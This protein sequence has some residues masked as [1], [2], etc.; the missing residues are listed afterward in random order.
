MTET[1][2]LPET[3]LPEPAALPEPEPQ[4]RCTLPILLELVKHFLPD[5][6]DDAAIL[7]LQL[8]AASPAHRVP[9][10]TGNALTVKG[11]A[12]LGEHRGLLL[13][14]VD[15]ICHRWRARPERPEESFPKGFPD[16]SPPNLPQ[17][18]TS[19]S[20]AL[21][22]LRGELANIIGD[23]VGDALGDAVGGAITAAIGGADK[24]VEAAAENE[25]T[26]E[27][28][29]PKEGTADQKKPAPKAK[30]KKT[31]EKKTEVKKTEVKT[32]AAGAD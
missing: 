20:P 30:L 28:P 16:V 2:A 18:K 8:M 19:K 21:D 13:D 25:R 11:L 6:E 9:L 5:K 22:I 7:I 26:P 10:I 32:K 27:T 31:E 4:N 17:G 12:A 3:A 23:A 24:P 29:P 15:R 1:P 14:L